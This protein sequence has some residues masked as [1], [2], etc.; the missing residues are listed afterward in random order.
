MLSLSF[1]FFSSFFFFFLFSLFYFSYVFCLSSS[2]SSLPPFQCSVSLSLS[3]FFL[4]PF[5]TV[6]FILHFVS[7]PFFHPR[8]ALLHSL[9]LFSPSCF[10]CIMASAVLFFFRFAFSSF[11]LFEFSVYFPFLPLHVSVFLFF[12]L[13]RSFFF[14]FRMCCFLS[15]FTFFLFLVFFFR[16]VSLLM[17]LLSVYAFCNL[18]S[19]FLHFSFSCIFVFLSCNF[20]PLEFFLMHFPSCIIRVIFK[21][22]SRITS[23]HVA[24]KRLFLS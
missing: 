12:L 23:F 7:S 15:F 24:F 10:P 18:F 9:F 17:H 8:S 1:P 11:H 20:S 21:Y 22:F 14:V 2:S 6:R 13:S 4:S 3:I 19:A 5:I 16:C